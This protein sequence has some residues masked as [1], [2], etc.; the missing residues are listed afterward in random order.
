MATNFDDSTA[1]DG[2]RNMELM[3]TEPRECNSG[4]L[5]IDGY[6]K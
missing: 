2:C 6:A 4:I 3:I 1:T 5:H